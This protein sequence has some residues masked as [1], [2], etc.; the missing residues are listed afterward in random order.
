MIIQKTNLKFSVIKILFGI[1]NI[2]YLGYQLSELVIKQ[3]NLFPYYILHNQ[4]FHKSFLAPC[5]INT[6]V[7]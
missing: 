5:L 4:M 6:I 2:E 7:C 3:T 1:T